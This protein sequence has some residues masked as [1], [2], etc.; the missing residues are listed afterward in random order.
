MTM[1]R[2]SLASLSV[3]GLIFAGGLALCRGPVWTGR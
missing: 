3:A 2:I 1:N